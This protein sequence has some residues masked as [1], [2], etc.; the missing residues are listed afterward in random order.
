MIIRRDNLEDLFSDSNFTHDY[1]WKTIGILV[2]PN[3]SCQLKENL[4]Q[5][6][7][8]IKVSFDLLVN[9][10]EILFDHFFRLACYLLNFIDVS[11]VLSFFLN[12]LALKFF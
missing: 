3:L 7:I 9:F 4:T 5:L 1:R 10:H 11:E 2:L 12:L 6:L 8:I